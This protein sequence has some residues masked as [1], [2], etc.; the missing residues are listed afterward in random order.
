MLTLLRPLLAAL[1]L[2]LMAAPPAVAQ[3]AYRVAPG[4]VLLLEV[5]EDPTMNRQLLVLPDGS[6][7]VPQGGTVRAS[8]MSVADVQA[9]VTLA[10]AP[11][12]AKAPTVYMAVAQLAQQVPGAGDTGPTIEVF[13]MGEVAKP[14]VAAVPTGTNALQFLAIAGGFTNFAATKRIQIRRVDKAGVERIFQFNYDA[15]LSGAKAT[16]IQLQDGDVIIVPQRKL[17]E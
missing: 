2:T 4:D 17:F 16:Q 11:S 10:L 6:I 8:G 14:G 7:N 5:L 1:V 3:A 15:L 13:V 12:F 9:A